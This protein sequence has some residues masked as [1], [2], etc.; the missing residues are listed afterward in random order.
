MDKRR[1]TALFITLWVG[2]MLCSNTA[3]C[4]QAAQSGQ[5][6]LSIE[7]KKITLVSVPG[8]S[9]IE[10]DPDS[11]KLSGIQGDALPHIKE[12]QRT[13]AWGAL[14]VRTPGKGLEDVYMSLGAGQYA[15][16]PPG[17]SGMQ[18]AERLGQAYAAEHILRYTGTAAEM[19]SIVIPQIEAI[20]RMNASNDYRA[21]PGRLGELL[22]AAG[23]H[24]GVWG[25][26]D[27]MK[28]GGRLK[29][30]EIGSLYRRYAPLMLMNEAGFVQ[31]GDVGGGDVIVDHTRPFGLRT[32]YGWLL[33]QR[34]KLPGPAAAL[35]EIGDLQRLYDER[36]S[37]SAEAFT[38]MKKQ[39]LTELDAFLGELTRQLQAESAAGQTVELWLFSPQVNAEAAKAKAMLAP[40]MIYAPSG[41]ESILTSATTRRPGL[42]SAVDIAPALLTA[43]GIQ[44]PA[45]MIGLP[46]V[47]EAAAD[48]FPKLLADLRQFR[49]LYAQRPPLLYA[50]AVYEIVVMLASLMAAWYFSGGRK[51]G[52]KALLLWRTLLYSLLLAPAGLLAMGWFTFERLSAAA[53]FVVG[54][55]LT[56]GL[57]FAV[58]AGRRRKGFVFSLAGIG[59]LVTALILY[60]GLHGAQAMQRS[61]LGYDPMIGARYYGIGNEFMG[62]LLGAALLGLSAAQQALRGLRWPRRPAAGEP[63][64]T[65]AASGA[66]VP[67]HTDALPPETA[68]AAALAAPAGIAAWRLPPLGALAPWRR[69]A[70]AGAASAAG[71]WPRR[72]AAGHAAA[73]VGAALPAAA[74]GALIAGYLAAPALGTNAG[75][76]LAAAAGFGAL[77]A[78][79]AGGRRWL[80]LAPVLTLTM[81]A[82]LAGLWLLNGGAAGAVAADKQS[83]IGRAFEALLQGRLDAIGAIVRR[84]L[85]M[86]AHLIRV[87]VWSKVLLTGLAVMAALVLRP[88]GP[89]RRWQRRYPYLMYGCAA[90]VI[91]TIFALALNDS[92][93]VAAATMIIYGSVPLLLLKLE[94]A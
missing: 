68:A 54:C 21:R 48:A 79:L 15:D 49:L 50:L 52:A 18:R 78:R 87:S 9:F 27:L 16:A 51:I 46:V 34:S 59:L 42:V 66:P 64:G 23:V 4:S 36:S 72:A 11:A 41:R 65:L 17:V 70:E 71:A 62:V 60:D 76:A 58:A 90:N 67:A 1:T 37:Y 22:A 6:S 10:L 20:K 82:A 86:N 74:A 28:A 12:L 40:V 43:F 88:R 8:L 56:G 75:G 92:G 31:R 5:L 85:E 91:G 93:I 2:A 73:R 57:L 30:R 81:A 3:V 80:R 29:E 53:L 45:D 26:L 33:E 19:E 77:A 84:K 83:H 14:N 13:A 69:A 94:S 63:P 55:V 25:N 89:F 32:N 35:L 44:P 47:R 24:S 38:V 61:V 7:D 39:V